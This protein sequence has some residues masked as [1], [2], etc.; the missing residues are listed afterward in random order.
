MRKIFIDD[1][2]QKQFE[3]NGYVL[4]DIFSERDIDSLQGIYD[5]NKTGGDRGLQL[6]VQDKDIGVIKNINCHTQGVS[7][8]LFKKVLLDYDIIYSGFIAKVPEKPNEAGIHRDPTF[9]D[10]NRYRTMVIWTPLIDVDETNGALYMIRNTN[11]NDQGYRFFDYGEYVYTTDE[12]EIQKE[13]GTLIR[14]KRGQSLIFDTTTLH[15]SLKNTTDITRVALS[16]ILK[17]SESDLL[18]YYHNKNRNTVDVYAIDQEFVLTYYQ[19]NGDGGDL[20]YPLMER[21]PF[22][23]PR[24]IGIDEFR[25]AYRLVNPDG[26]MTPITKSASLGLL[27]KIRRWFK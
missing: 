5:G 20:D 22:H 18:A 9:V 3:E 8:D 2:V 7:Q 25:R 10:E 13:F 19:K 23:P 21:L 12:A 26:H 16:V 15:F 11:K 6:S 1:N 4:M 14:M 17:P 24:N 27:D